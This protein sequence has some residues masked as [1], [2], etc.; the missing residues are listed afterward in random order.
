VTLRVGPIIVVT[1]CTTAVIA[2]PE[3]TGARVTVKSAGPIVPDGKPV[4]VTLTNV[5]P[6]SAAPG[7]VAA[8]NVTGTGLAA[9]TV[10][11]PCTM[12]SAPPEKIRLRRSTSANRRLSTKDARRRDLMGGV[13]PQCFGIA[14]LTPTPCGVNQPRVPSSLSKRPKELQEWLG[15]PARLRT[16]TQ[17]IAAS[18]SSQTGGSG[19]GGVTTEPFTLISA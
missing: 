5:T 7:V 17:V 15:C 10:L 4:P 13:A 11:I 1:D 18:N 12:I 14:W 8:V 6:G 3:L 19:T 16:T 9:C 2:G